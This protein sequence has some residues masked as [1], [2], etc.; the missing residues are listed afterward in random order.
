M[1]QYSILKTQI[2][3]GN[4]MIKELDKV[5]LPWMAVVIVLPLLITVLFSAKPVEA[6]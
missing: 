6:G 5:V 1:L 2:K 4:G 3:W